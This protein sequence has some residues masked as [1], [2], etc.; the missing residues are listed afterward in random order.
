MTGPPPLPIEAPLA[1]EAVEFDLASEAAEEKTSKRKTYGPYIILYSS[2]GIFV[3]ALGGYYLLFVDHSL[4]DRLQDVVWIAVG[5]AIIGVGTYAV[6]VVGTNEVIRLR[7]DS[8]GPSFTH[9]NGNLESWRW[10][11]PKLKIDICH[12][13]GSVEEILPKEDARRLRRDW[14]DV[15]T[16]SGRT[17]QLETTLPPAA[18]EALAAAAR[19]RGAA[20][21]TANVA[22][23][24]EFGGEHSPG[25]LSHEFEGHLSKKHTI[26]G[27]IIE[28]RP[29][30]SKPI[31][32]A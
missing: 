19:S 16:R 32:H 18:A 14:V 30:F 26:N 8:N 3:A 11:D 10:D 15:Y 25:Y 12:F 1:S 17:L 27:E 24:W 29:G 5:S 31:H 22:F 13:T 2:I 6:R 4:S 23:Y 21:R 28:I 9:K 7:V 20:I